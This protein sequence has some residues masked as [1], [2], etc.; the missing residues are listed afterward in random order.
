MYNR[1]KKSSYLTISAL[2][3]SLTAATGVNAA[4]I[5]YNVPGSGIPAAKFNKDIKEML[6]VS[7]QKSGVIKIATDAHYPP[8]ESFAPDNKS[9]VGYEPDLWIAISQ[10]LGIKY[11]AK[12]IDFSGLIPGVD[13]K[14]YDMASECI[15]DSKAREHK[16]MFVEDA[17]ATGAV[18]TLQTNKSISDKTESL[19]GLTVGIQQGID[20]EKVVKDEMTPYCVSKNLKPIT[21]N[22][23]PSGQDVLLALYSGRVDFVLNDLAASKKIKEAAPHPIRIETNKFLPKYY[24]GIVVAKHNTKLANALLAALKEIKQEGIYQ[25]IMSK[26]E[27]SEL[28]LDKFGI[29]MVTK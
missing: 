13:S 12:S 15:S 22:L 28:S 10:K 26:W 6:P 11:E 19:C 23:Y 9:M 7:I 5:D 17:F 3:L 18:Y 20:F 1:R 2:V 21:V 27:I 16:V 29:N 25:K 8:C 4:S 14:R 24:N